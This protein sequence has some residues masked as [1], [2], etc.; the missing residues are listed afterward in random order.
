M[1]DQHMAR[2]AFV[3]RLPKTNGKVGFAA[4]IDDGPALLCTERHQDR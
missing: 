3:E 2:L 1:C 4:R